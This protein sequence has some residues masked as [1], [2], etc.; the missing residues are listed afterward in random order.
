MPPILPPEIFQ[1]IFEN[2]DDRKTLCHILITSRHLCQLVEPLLYTRIR[3]SQ[4]SFIPI[5]SM[6]LH[7]LLEGL[8]TGRRARYV[9]DLYLGADVTMPGSCT[10]IDKILVK[11][12]HLECLTLQLFNSDSS[13]G[14]RFA[15]FQRRL[16]FNLTSL[17]LSNCGLYL[18]HALLHLLES[19]TS[20][21]ILNLGFPRGHEY[22]Y[23]FSPTS[24]PNLKVL[25]THSSLASTFLRTS[26]RITRL[27]ISGSTRPPH[28]DITDQ[29]CA[30]TVRTLSSQ[31]SIDPKTGIAFASLLPNLEWF[32]GAIDSAEQLEHLLTHNRKLRGVRIVGF[33]PSSCSG[34]KI[35]RLFGTLATLQFLEYGGSDYKPYRW[36]RGATAP[37]RI[38]WLCEYDSKWLADWEEDVVYEINPVAH[39][40]KKRTQALGFHPHTA[41]PVMMRGRPFGAGA[42]GCLVVVSIATEQERVGVGTNHCESAGSTFGRA[43]QEGQERQHCPRDMLLVR[44]S[45]N[46][47]RNTQQQGGRTLTSF[48]DEMNESRVI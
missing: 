30:D 46:R 24:F 6:R 16:T 41:L 15:L 32:S 21:K 18:D 10:L 36:Y 12:T 45:G 37:S 43:W 34:D 11:T 13:S 44:V 8:E 17:T 26:A 48:C 40:A 20:L 38:R 9:R 31:I 47:L 4:H 2:V 1:I 33:M 27:Q 7:S 29:H 42:G 19:Q 22:G 14:W 28:S 39:C 23:E 35:H 3:I 25:S 5:H